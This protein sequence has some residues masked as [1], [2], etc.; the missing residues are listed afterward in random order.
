MHLITSFSSILLTYLL[1][2]IKSHLLLLVLIITTCYFLYKGLRKNKSINGLYKTNARVHTWSNIISTLRST[3]TCIGHDLNFL[4]A[5][6]QLWVLV[7]CA[8]FWTRFASR[9]RNNTSLFERIE[10]LLQQTSQVNQLLPISQ[11]LLHLIPNNK[12]YDLICRSLETCKPTTTPLLHYT[13]RFGYENITK[14]LL[15]NP[16]IQENIN[17]TD[18]HGWTAFMYAVVKG[19]QQISNALL[20]CPKIAVSVEA[21]TQLA[22]ALCE[23]YKDDTLFDRIEGLL[24]LADQ[25]DR[26]RPISHQPLKFVSD[27]NELCDL[28]CRSLQAATP[29]TT[30]LLHYTCCFGYENITKILLQNPYIQKN[31]NQTDEHGWTALMYAVQA[32][33]DQI[34]DTLL[35]CPEIDVSIKDKNGVS[36]LALCNENSALINRIIDMEISTVLKKLPTYYFLSCYNPHVKRLAQITRNII[37]KETDQLSQDELKLLKKIW[38]TNNLMAIFRNHFYNTNR[39]SS[40][41]NTLAIDREKLTQTFRSLGFQEEDI[42]EKCYSPWEKTQQN[43][44]KSVLNL[45]RWFNFFDTKNS[46]PLHDN[47]NTDKNGAP[48]P[49]F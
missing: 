46:A 21:K 37:E 2:I 44:E 23:T 28:I 38:E 47:D 16:Y 4:A 31:I 40:K 45:G 13:C 15:Q 32:E 33:N 49:S 14:I 9:T 12:L 41:P 39:H 35:S 6:T 36:C 3:C 30:P 34:S 26:P 25:P 1:L 29:S 5:K 10:A 17:Q 27:N 42:Y 8:H 24:K 43:P 11:W 48:Y 18:E 20:S 19:H 7:L 22:Y